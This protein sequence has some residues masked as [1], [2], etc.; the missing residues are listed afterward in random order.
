MIGVSGNAL[1]CNFYEANGDKLSDRARNL[2]AAD[3]VVLKVFEGA[4]QSAIFAALVL[5]I[6]DHEPQEDLA[7]GR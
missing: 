7:S 1:A 2:I 5:S 4:R 6:L 3:A